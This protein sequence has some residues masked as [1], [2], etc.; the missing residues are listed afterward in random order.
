MTGQKPVVNSPSSAVRSS[1]DLRPVSARD[2]RLARSNRPDW[3]QYYMG[4]AIAVRER[5]NCRGSR[6][7]ALLVRDNRILT[8]GYNGTPQNIA[9]C[10]EGG[11]ERCAD[12]DRYRSGQAYDLCI[13]V[14]AEQNA[15]ITAARFGISVE[16][17]SMYTTL[18]PCFGCSKE[19]LQARVAAV[20]YMHEWSPADDLSRPELRKI[21]GRFPKG[22]KRVELDDPRAEW[23]VPWL[24]PGDHQDIAEVSQT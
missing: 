2:Q 14:H 5:A 21:H 15:L 12:R 16:G 11:C 7:G 19:L 8:T 20:H 24:N 18:Q 13:C 17:S 10:D 1:P 23:A 4:I 6:V 3:H 22:M 9:N